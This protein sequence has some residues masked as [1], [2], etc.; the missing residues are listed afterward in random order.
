MRAALADLPLSPLDV[1]HAGRESYP[2]AKRVNAASAF[3]LLKD[4]QG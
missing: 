4:I 3:R 2:L 1:I